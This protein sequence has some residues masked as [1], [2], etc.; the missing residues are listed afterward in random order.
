MAGDTCYHLASVGF[1]YFGAHRMGKITLSFMAL[2]TDGIA[3]SLEH[4][5]II[6]A[7]RFMTG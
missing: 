1:Q 7:M 3:T 5:Q 6:A 4:S 2:D